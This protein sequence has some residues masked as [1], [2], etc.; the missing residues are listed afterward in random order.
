AVISY[1][2]IQ[3]NDD[4]EFLK[5]MYIEDVD[6]TLVD[7]GNYYGTYSVFPVEVELIVT[8]EDHEITT[9]NII[10]HMNGQ[11]EP[12]EVI[13]DDIIESQTLQVDAIAG[14]TYSS[15]VI[16]LAVQNALLNES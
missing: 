3:I 16:L 11:G 15:K 5:T 1:F 4:L 10:R 9:I 6:L 14:A 13:V 2:V 12:A 7:D 8:V